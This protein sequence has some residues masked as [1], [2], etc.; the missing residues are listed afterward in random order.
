MSQEAATPQPNNPE[1]VVTPRDPNVGSHPT[2]ERIAK[3]LESVISER[4]SGDYKDLN[5]GQKIFLKNWLFALS[6]YAS[7]ITEEKRR[8]GGGGLPVRTLPKAGSYVISGTAEREFYDRLLSGDP[9]VDK[10]KQQFSPQD[11]IYTTHPNFSQTRELANLTPEILKHFL[12]MSQESLEALG[13][14]EE[15][16]K[17]VLSKQFADNG[18]GNDFAQALSYIKPRKGRSRADEL[19]EAAVDLIPRVYEGITEEVSVILKRARM[20]DAKVGQ[21]LSFD[22]V[23]KLS[24]LTSDHSTWF[25]DGD[26]KRTSHA[27]D[28]NFAIPGIKA[29]AMDQFLQDLQKVKGRVSHKQEIAE[30]V[31]TLIEELET[32]KHI[33]ESV[34]DSARGV[35]LALTKL[36]TYAENHGETPVRDEVEDERLQL[37]AA[38]QKA[39]KAYDMLMHQPET[40][41]ALTTNYSEK[42]LNIAHTL[43]ELEAKG[44]VSFQK[45]PSA[46]DDKTPLTTLDGLIIKAAKGDFPMKVERRE[47][48]NQHKEAMRYFLK[49]LAN[50]GL[51][52]SLDGMAIPGSKTGEKLTGED[53]MNALRATTSKDEQKLRKV[54]EVVDGLAS[55]A[56]TPGA[57]S[58]EEMTLVDKFKEILKNSYEATA[59]NVAPKYHKSPDAIPLELPVNE[60]VF[61]DDVAPFYISGKL[62][63][64]AFKR[65]IIAE[66]GS[67]PNQ[68]LSQGN[69]SN[70]RQEAILRDSNDVLT[71]NIFKNLLGS[72]VDV[73]PLYEDPDAIL[74]TPAMLSTKLANTAYHNSLGIDMGKASEKSLV[75]T[76][77]QEMTAYE[78]LRS[79]GFSDNAMS[80]RKMDI[81]ELKDALVYVGPHKMLANSDSAK[82]GT[83]ASST[84]NNITV[85]ESYEAASRHLLADEKG[86]KYLYV[87]QIYQGQ[88]GSL[89]RTTGTD[90]M[91]NTITEQG[92]HTTFTTGVYSAIKS[93][94]RAVTRLASKTQAS[95]TEGKA[96]ARITETGAQRVALETMALGNPYG[97]KLDVENMQQLKEAC[98]KAIRKRIAGTRDDILVPGTGKNGDADNSRYEELLR[99]YGEDF[100]ENYSA[101]PASKGGKVNYVGIRAIGLAGKEFGIFSNIMGVSEM[102]EIDKGGK[103]TNLNLMSKMYQGDPTVKHNLDA[104]AYTACLSSKTLPRV[105]EK[106]EVSMRVADDG[107]VHLT[108]KGVEVELAQLVGAYSEGQTHFK[109]FDAADLALANIHQQTLNFVNGLSQIRAAVAIGPS[110]EGNYAPVQSFRVR[111]PIE[112]IPEHLRPTVEHARGLADEMSKHFREFEAK[113]GVVKNMKENAKT[114]E[115]MSNDAMSLRMAKDAYYQLMETSLEQQALSRVK[116][117]GVAA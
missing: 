74:N 29:A 117:T 70:I 77:G 13:R 65:V 116:L 25:T 30:S 64:D 108:K 90:S 103:L 114:P 96:E 22:Q 6:S 113:E 97:F 51:N 109:Q 26:G 102:F 56:L 5:A 71:A 43:K 89:A 39:G 14:N 106:G 35:M 42:V 7:E 53:F 55:R 49:T 87:N 69:L 15:S 84:L 44:E 92:Q 4:L 60:S 79:Q 32:K 107:S 48:A 10:A 57:L 52:H 21:T 83:L 2:P 46:F 111:D 66:A 36:Q 3:A 110:K 27:W 88:G 73:V 37:R 12:G 99:K 81:A 33:V 63:N 85:V 93:V 9:A 94:L 8:L 62:Y 40:I 101:R 19:D 23:K 82:R 28:N 61:L 86:K 41:E 105:W 58:D 95:E 45:M 76:N 50:V 20:V 112:L 91:V 100:I 47:N 18:L 24:E 54:M 115:K 31:D 16:A 72:K 78:F 67:P 38:A 104:A 80:M 98:L 68:M 11:T 34:R 59:N 75:K 1:P 17:A